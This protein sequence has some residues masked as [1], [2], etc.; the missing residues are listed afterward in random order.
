[1]QIETTTQP[2]SEI[3][4]DMEI[5]CVVEKNL[6]HPWIAEDKE[7]LKLSGFEGGQDE[8]CLLAESGRIYVGPIHCSMMT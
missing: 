4:A 1:M 6:D 8:T 3:K 7:I 2:R 5:V